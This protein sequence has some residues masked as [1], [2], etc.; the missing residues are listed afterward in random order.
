MNETLAKIEAGLIF[1]LASPLFLFLFIVHLIEKAQMRSN[2]YNDKLFKRR[3]NL[4]DSRHVI[5]L[6]KWNNEY[7][8]Q[9]N[10]DDSEL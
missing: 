2:S 3:F 10:L 1:V 4:I 9:R 5:D 8:N 7:R 6:V